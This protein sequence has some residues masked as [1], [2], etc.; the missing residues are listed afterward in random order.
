MLHVDAVQPPQNPRQIQIARDA[1]RMLSCRDRRDVLKG[2]RAMVSAIPT[3][4]S[5]RRHI[6]GPAPSSRP[7]RPART[8]CAG[9][10]RLECSES[11]STLRSALCLAVRAQPPVAQLESSPPIVARLARSW[12]WDHRPLFSCLDVADGGNGCAAFTHT[13]RH[14]R[15]AEG[16]P[17]G[18]A[19]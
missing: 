5:P 12:T 18:D 15:R 19:R 7:A 17:S 11:S 9:M 14:G 16:R 10:G 2:T 8:G 1:W 3:C 6:A 13:A 4:A